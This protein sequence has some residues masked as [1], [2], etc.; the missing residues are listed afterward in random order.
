MNMKTIAAALTAGALVSACANMPELPLGDLKAALPSV[1]T[2]APAVASTAFQGLLSQRAS[3]AWP[4]VALTIHAMHPTAFSN[5][6]AT[7]G[8]TIQAN[9]C[10]R[11][12]A[13]VW[14][15]AKT[16]RQIPEETFCPGQLPP[17]MS[18]G[19]NSAMELV[20]WSTTYSVNYPMKWPDTGSNRTKGPNPPELLYPAGPEYKGLWQAQGGAV[21]NALVR[22]MGYDLS[23]PAPEQNRRL[24]IVSMPTE[25][26][27]KSGQK[28]VR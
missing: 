15:D 21:F 16:S 14:T 13:V 12:S 26:E 24:W 9:A 3:G 19:F 10:M 8:N 11:I 20:A 4:R 18:V 2:S 5:K 23:T 7:W 27:V 22:Y 28:V 1:S 25:Y 17:Q 6:I